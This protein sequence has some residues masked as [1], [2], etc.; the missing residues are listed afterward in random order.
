M[1]QTNGNKNTK[2]SKKQEKK[3]Y[4]EK[5]KSS[6]GGSN[7]RKDKVNKKGNTICTY[8][9]KGWN[10]ESA[11]MNKTI[12]M[13]VQLL[14]KNNI[15]LP[16]GTRKKEGALNSKKKERCHALVYGYSESF[17][18]LIDSG[19]SWHMDSTQD[20]FLALH[21]YSG[22]STLMGGYFE[23]QAKRIGRINLDNGYF[24]NVLYLPD[25]VENLL[26][27]Y[28]MKHTGKTK[29]VTFTQN[30]TDISEISIGQVVTEGIVDHDSR[31]Y[32]FSHFHP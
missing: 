23:I 26:S 18:F 8:Y 10:I 28:K 27:I 11:C 29:R 22:P 19:S 1:N 31:M 25:I 12:D 9:R 21:T 30:D 2:D 16:Y 3:K 4:K 17:S 14:E 24:N 6:D 7:P 15:P 32:K 5:P 13:M 20:S